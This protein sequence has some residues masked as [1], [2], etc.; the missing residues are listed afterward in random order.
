MSS[1]VPSLLLYHHPP[2]IAMAQRRAQAQPRLRKT[3]SVA[4]VEDFD[5][6][7]S[8]QSTGSDDHAL[9]LALAQQITASKEKKRKDMEKKFFQAAK[10]KLTGDITG[11]AD[12]VKNALEETEALYAKFI[13]DYAASEDTIRGLWVQIQVEEQTLVAIAQRQREANAELRVVTETA[14]IAGMAQVKEACHETRNVI[15]TLLPVS[16]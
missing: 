14:Q 1:R 2:I 15:E 3:E 5:F 12:N 8:Q 16:F 6:L 13:T 4:P 7:A 11:A 9:Q 10:H